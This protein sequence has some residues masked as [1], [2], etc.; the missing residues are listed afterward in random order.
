[1]LSSKE[2]WN[3]ISNYNQ[4]IYPMQWIV[5]LV[6]VIVTLY[7]IY[8]NRVRANIATKLYLSLC[9][10]WIGVVFFMVLGEGFPSPLKQVQ[11]SLFVA[12][13][14]LFAIDIFT[15]KTSFTIPKRG[16]KRIVTITLLLVVLVYPVV[17]VISGH[18]VDKLIYP[19][20][21]PCPTTAFALVLLTCALPKVNKATYLLLL[22]WAIPFAPLIQIP[23]YHVYEDGIMFVVG[24]FA[25]IAL[26]RS[27]IKGKR[28][29]KLKAHKQL[30]DIKKDAVFATSSEDGVPNIVPIHSKHL[31][32]N[33]KVLISDQFMDKTKHNIIANPYGTLTIKE[34]DAVYSISG[35]CRYKTSGF[36]YRMAVKG[37]KK[38]AKK[39]AKNK[40]IKIRCKGI[41]L[42][43]VDSFKMDGRLTA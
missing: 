32:S 37:V 29:V 6:G 25:L 35:K 14:V 3:V 34:N 5:M 12:I 7:Q 27:I 1:M 8:G 36:L 28:H 4:S 20:T 24:V 40:N 39:N 18:G 9:N 15:R 33:N 13:G 31:I 19:G 21:L 42:M 11:G 26:I 16:P 38:Y 22:V 2:W 17:G 23:K 30:F 10:L 41:V 43:K